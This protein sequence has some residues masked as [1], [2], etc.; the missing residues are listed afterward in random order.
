MSGP[1]P[2][3]A[4]N[5]AALA[6]T[7]S[8]PAS[9][10]SLNPSLKVTYLGVGEAFDE[11]EPNTCLLVQ[12][13]QTTLLLDCGF[14][15]IPRIWAA[16]PDP[17][18]LDGVYLSHTHADH[19][20]G[21]PGLLVRFA[22]EGRQK[23]LMILGRPGL[24]NHVKRVVD[25]AYPGITSRLTYQLRFAVLDPAGAGK[26]K[27]TSTLNADESEATI[28]DLRLRAAP[29]QH[30]VPSMGLRVDWPAPVSVSEA[31]RPAASDPAAF[32]SL[33]YSGDGMWTEATAVLYSGC[34][35]L[36]HECYLEE[37]ETRGHCSVEA[38]IELYRRVKPK[39]MA[40]VHLGRT[41]RPK[42][43]ELLRR[44]EEDGLAIGVPEGGEVIEL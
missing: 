7:G 31:V 18:L 26:Q 40:L 23:P 32:V 5:C 16:L 2:A 13:Q 21:L 28:G 36:V 22:E 17:E 6:R 30:S 34:D 14:S 15:A 24:A 19:L 3:G 12:S 8:A 25:F 4:I 37:G 43:E 39:R 44:F 33:C 35:L 42:R 41:L 38:A 1:A 10:A 20:F 11:K 27:G 29:T 9:K